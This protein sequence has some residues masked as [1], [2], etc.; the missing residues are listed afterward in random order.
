MIIVPDAPI[1]LLNDQSITNRYRIGFTWDAGFSDGGIEVLD[2]R[3]SYDQSFGVWTYLQDQIQVLEYTTALSLTEG[4]TYS[5]KVEARNEVGYSEYSEVISILAG[6]IP[7]TPNAPTTTS[8][9][10]N[11]LISW[12]APDDGGTSI[13][14]YTISIELKDGLSYAEE[15]VNCDGT[16]PT[17]VAE[18]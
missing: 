18:R 13:I 1:N 17:I 14:A 7:E 8:V 5:F 9:G 2:Y 12:D 15:L 16:D 6:Q 3:V 4:N 10:S 11:T